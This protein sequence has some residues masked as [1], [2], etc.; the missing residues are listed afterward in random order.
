MPNFNGFI[1][2]DFGQKVIVNSNYEAFTSGILHTSSA[3]LPQTSQSPIFD[4]SIGLLLAQVPL[5]SLPVT[6]CLKLISTNE[7]KNV[8]KMITKM[9]KKSFI[10]CDLNGLHLTTKVNQIS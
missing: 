3:F 5:N 4:L 2:T 9:N 10:N 8:P 7:I 1:Y 6:T